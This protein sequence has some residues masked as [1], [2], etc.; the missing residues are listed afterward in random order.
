MET[1]HLPVRHSRSIART[2]ARLEASMRAPSDIAVL[3]EELNKA[4]TELNKTAKREAPKDGVSVHKAKMKG[5]DLVLILSTGEEINVGRVV[6]EDGLDGDDAE[7]VDVK[8]LE[9]R[10]VA[11]IPKP[12]EIDEPALLKKLLSLVPKEQ[13]LEAKDIIAEIKKGKLLS[14]NDLKDKPDLGKVIF[15]HTKHYGNRPTPRGA[16]SL[17]QLTDV[18]LTALPQDTKGNYVLTPGGMTFAVPVGTVDG[19]NVSFVVT[20]IPKFIISDNTTYIEGFGYSRSG[21]NITMDLPPV[22]FIRAVS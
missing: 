6:G 22:T 9:E 5:K 16:S 15:E 14:Y 17:G 12:K 19:A 7:P 21:L 10:I 13:R 8:A 11:R 20:A 2:I 1:T 3:L 4:I 18:D